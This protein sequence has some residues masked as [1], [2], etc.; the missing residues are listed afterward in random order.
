MGKRLY[1]IE[2]KFPSSSPRNIE[3][4]EAVYT[5]VCGM[6]HMNKYVYGKMNEEEVLKDIEIG[7]GKVFGWD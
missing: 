4:D 1:Q 7:Y 5:C 6:T 3:I 2:H